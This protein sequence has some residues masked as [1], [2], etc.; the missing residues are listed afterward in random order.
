MIL[1]SKTI[2]IEAHNTHSNKCSI[3]TCPGKAPMKLIGTRGN[4]ISGNW[5]TVLSYTAT[6]AIW[7]LYRLWVKQLLNGNKGKR[8][9]GRSRVVLYIKDQWDVKKT[10]VYCSVMGNWLFP[11]KV[12]HTD[13]ELQRKSRNRG[14][15]KHAGKERPAANCLYC[16]RLLIQ[17]WQLLIET[18]M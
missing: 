13:S 6:Y 7:L 18:L 11:C 16:S 14:W 4:Q 5:F 10:K 8:K 1:S 3:T 2:F 9:R 17:M 15:Y 12:S